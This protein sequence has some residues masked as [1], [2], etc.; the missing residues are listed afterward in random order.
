[1]SFLLDTHAF[2]WWTTDADQ[3][4]ERARQLIEDRSEPVYLSLVCV[5]EI[6]IKSQLGRLALEKSLRDLVEVELEKNLLLLPIAMEHIL[7]LEALPFYHRDP[8][9]RLLVAQAACEGFQII[10][11]DPEFSQY[12]V[13]LIWNSE[14]NQ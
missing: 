7:K 13:Q 1:M 2:L 9:D 8:F 3:L 11:K 14:R 4:P 10:T 5:W 12:G 6:Q